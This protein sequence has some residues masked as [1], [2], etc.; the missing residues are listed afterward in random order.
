M[1]RNLRV[2]QRSARYPK[3]LMNLRRKQ[4]SLRGMLREA[5]A[6]TSCCQPNVPQAPSMVPTGE[7][8][9]SALG[10]VV[11][12][13]QDHVQLVNLGVCQRRLLNFMRQR[14]LLSIQGPVKVV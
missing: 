4:P 6:G 11:A 5:L 8:V 14:H 3:R 7:K 1:D 10:G 12:T 2:A 13:L 9:E